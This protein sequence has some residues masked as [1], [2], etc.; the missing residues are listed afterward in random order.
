MRGSFL[1]L[2]L[3]SIMII[4]GCGHRK[5]AI[6]K[7]GD[8]A[9]YKMTFVKDNNLRELVLKVECGKAVGEERTLDVSYQ[10]KSNNWRP[11]Y[12]VVV[13]YDKSDLSNKVEVRD[14]TGNVIDR[15]HTISGVPVPFHNLLFHPGDKLPKQKVTLS[16]G[17]DISSYNSA[18]SF[19]VDKP[20][21]LK[22]MLYNSQKSGQAIGYIETQD[23]YPDEWLWRKVTRESD[24]P[25]DPRFEL[26]RLDSYSSNRY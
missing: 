15:G 18:D 12:T 7:I 10:I 6:P 13:R 16:Y 1:L 19:I 24:T 23:W 8:N 4:N 5:T 21:R 2:I 20:F 14:L 22:F 9:I 3:S 17:W 25:G 26:I 11:A